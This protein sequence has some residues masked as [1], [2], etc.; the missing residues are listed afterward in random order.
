MT[1]SSPSPILQWG[2]GEQRRLLVSF[3]WGR[4]SKG[5]SRSRAAWLRQRDR[6]R[7]GGPRTFTYSM[8]G[9]QAG[10]DLLIWRLAPELDALED[11]AA[12]LLRTGLGRWMSVTHCSSAGSGRR[13]TSASRR[14]RSSRCSPATARLPGR[15]P[16]HQ[17]D[18]LVPPRQ[19]GAP[20]RDERAHARRPRLPDRPPAAGLLVRARFPGFR[21]RLRDRRSRR[22]RRPRPRPALHGEPAVDGQRHADPAGDPP[23]DRRDP[24]ACWGPHRSPPSSL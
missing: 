10:T 12:A 16:V 21:R 15:L 22:V 1:L 4:P 3:A 11:A 18:R 20:G 5:G 23:P 24:R 2:E 6:P 7:A 9:L 8:I 17:V 19:G 13:S 14:S